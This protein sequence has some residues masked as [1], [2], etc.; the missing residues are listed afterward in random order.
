M[1][2]PTPAEKFIAS[3]KIYL[4]S[5]KDPSE[6]FSKLNALQDELQTQ[7][8]DLLKHA[9][10]GDPETWFAL[11]L[12]YSNGWGTDRDITKARIWF[13]H[14]ADAGHAEAMCQLASKLRFNTDD[15]DAL[16]LYLKAAELGNSSAMC[17]LAYH[18]RTHVE[19]DNASTKNTQSIDWFKQAIDA[20]DRQ[21]MIHIAKVYIEYAETPEEAIPWL[22]KAHDEGYDA[23]HI[24]L[25][26]LYNTPESSFY[27]PAE[28]I[29][30]YQ[31]VAEL[32]WVSTPRSMLEL[33]RL[34]RAGHGHASGNDEAKLWL[35]RLHNAVPEKHH[36]HKQ[37]TKL[38][39]KMNG[40]FF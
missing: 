31:R 37:A 6:Y 22:L 32:P 25:A 17:F 5:P 10:G 14:A 36:L 34:Y 3:T 30:W 35:H 13:Q 16:Q 1:S 8:K 26:D 9:K 23:S 24:M 33:A 27:N 4:E 19:E 12:G 15:D 2:K 40:E 39:D 38:L 28:A 7:F 11:G 21:A 18:Y 29:K 20:G